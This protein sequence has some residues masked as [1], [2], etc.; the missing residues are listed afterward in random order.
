MDG[1][2]I[3]MVNRSAAEWINLGTRLYRISNK[4]KTNPICGLDVCEKS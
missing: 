3:R 2:L 4:A 1:I